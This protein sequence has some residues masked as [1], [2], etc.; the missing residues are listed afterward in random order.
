MAFYTILKIPKVVW[1]AFDTIIW[2]RASFTILLA[3]YTGLTN[4]WIPTNTIQTSNFLI[5]LLAVGNPIAKAYLVDERM[6]IQ[7]S[8]TYLF[9]NTVNAT[10][11][12]G[13]A[14][15]LWNIFPQFTGGADVEVFT[16]FAGDIAT[17]ADEIVIVVG[18]VEVVAGWAGGAIGVE[19]GAGGAIFVAFEAWELFQEISF[20][21]EAA[22]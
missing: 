3:F 21:A 10:R 18:V 14:S 13:L 9:T 11:Q 20:L 16:G 19:E 15:T 4:H 7:A 12:A 22:G 2:T 17:I 8:D 6:I 1:I 5:T